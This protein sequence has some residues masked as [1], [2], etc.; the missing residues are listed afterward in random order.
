MFV[1]FRRSFSTNWV[2]TADCIF[3]PNGLLA[4]KV[5]GPELLKE[6]LNK[7]FVYT[8]ELCPSSVF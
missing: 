5:G 1:A 7:L 2:E 3:S 6:L 8:Y 4:W